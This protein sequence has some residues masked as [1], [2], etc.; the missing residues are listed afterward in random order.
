MPH[1]QNTRSMH[2]LADL[3]QAIEERRVHATIRNGMYVVRW[4]ELD[5][6]A[7]GTGSASAPDT[8]ASRRTAS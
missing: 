4:A 3:C 5:R 2:T 7:R 8:L 6:L 1:E